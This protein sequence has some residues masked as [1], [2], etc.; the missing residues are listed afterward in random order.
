MVS[1]RRTTAGALSRPGGE[2]PL[3]PADI[4]GAGGLC[5][6]TPSKT[7]QCARIWGWEPPPTHTHT[8]LAGLLTTR[9]EKP[10]RTGGLRFFFLENGRRPSLA[11]LPDIF[12]RARGRKRAARLVGRQQ[13]PGAAVPAL[14]P[15]SVVTVSKGSRRGARERWMGAECVID[16]FFL[17]AGGGGESWG[18]GGGKR[19]T[20][21]TRARVAGGAFRNNTASLCRSLSKRQKTWRATSPSSIDSPS[22]PLS[23]PPL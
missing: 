3:G 13:Q 20:T 18:S 16:L 5:A 10:P 19:G 2:R 7:P 11:R 22:D 23:Q 1:H 4:V 21:T 15:P 12:I 9:R 14:A 17:G 6:G 8:H